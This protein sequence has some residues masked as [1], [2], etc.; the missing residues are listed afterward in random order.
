VMSLKSNFGESRVSLKFFQIKVG[1]L[2]KTNSILFIFY[3]I[4][5]RRK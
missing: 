3:S 4:S 5:S 2:S 1:R